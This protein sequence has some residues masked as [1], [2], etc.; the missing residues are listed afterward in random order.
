VTLQTSGPGAGRDGGTVNDDDIATLRGVRPD[1]W[2]GVFVDVAIERGA[3][4]YLSALELI[5]E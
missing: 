2:G 5:A 3:F 4:A 1:A